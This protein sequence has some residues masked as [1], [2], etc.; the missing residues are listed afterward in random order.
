MVKNLLKIFM[1]IKIISVTI[2]FPVKVIVPDVN[3]KMSVEMF[4]HGL[5]N[6][7]SNTIN[8]EYTVSRSNH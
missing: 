2:T 1:R 3:L 8:S 5:L 6:P 4:D 7:M